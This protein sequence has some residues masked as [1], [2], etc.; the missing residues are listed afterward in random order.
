[1]WKTVMGNKALLP[2]VYSLNRSN[3]YLIPSSFDPFDDCFE[4][5]EYIIE[6]GLTGRGSMSTRTIK[7]KDI[8]E[9]KHNVIYQKIFKENKYKGKYYIM[10]SYIVGKE[11]SGMF[12][13]QSEKMI[14]EYSCNVIPVRI[15]I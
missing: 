6:K 5:D 9:R 7:R 14:N 15:L 10:G 2:Y 8:K 12:I 1:M 11:F 13:K 4:D 3:P